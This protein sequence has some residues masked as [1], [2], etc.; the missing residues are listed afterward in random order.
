MTCAAKKDNF[1]YNSGHFNHDGGTLPPPEAT[2]IPD[3][4]DWVPPTPF[5]VWARGGT[6]RWRHEG[7]LTTD[8]PAR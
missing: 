2:R 1:D 6:E 4:D 8:P 7:R 3:D 5:Q